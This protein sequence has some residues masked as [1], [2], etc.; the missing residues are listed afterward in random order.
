MAGPA[1]KAHAPRAMAAGSWSIWM[2]TARIS[3]KSFKRSLHRCSPERTISPSPRAPGA[4]GSGAQW[5]WHQLASGKIIGALAGLLYGFRYT[6]MCAFR[7][8]RRDA[9]FSLGMEEMT[10]GWNLEMQ[11]KA[12]RAGLRILEVPIPYACRTGG[13]SKVA[14]SAIGTLRAGTRIL[15]TFARVALQP[16][17]PA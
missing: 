14:G 9:L 4:N 2:A 17:R 16:K 1:W 10:Y 6:D 7:A 5:S 8:I 11:M 15:L 3:R 13:N 12:A